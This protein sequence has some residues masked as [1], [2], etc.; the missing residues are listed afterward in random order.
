MNSE[1]PNQS[2]KL[3]GL[4]LC[5]LLESIIP[6]QVM[7]SQHFNG[8]W[9]IWIKTKEARQHLAELGSIEINN[10][11]IE[12]FTTCPKMTPVPNEKIVLKDIP[13]WVPDSDVI[14]FLNN[15]QGIIVK[16]GVITARFRDLNNKLT[17]YFTGDRFV[18]VKGKMTKALHHSA[19]INYAKCRIWHKKSGVGLQ[20]M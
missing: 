13:V 17:P 14:Q 2:G 4:N 6:G 5:E 20:E 16:S 18:F 3:M 15:Q 1:L 10:I 12:L 8:I 11:R 9:S 7:G 19:L